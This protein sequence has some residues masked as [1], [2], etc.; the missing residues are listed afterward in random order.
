VPNQSAQGARR[1]QGGERGPLQGALRPQLGQGASDAGGEHR[2]AEAVGHPSQQED[3]EVRLQ[4]Q[5]R[6][7]QALAQVDLNKKANVAQSVTPGVCMHTGSRLAP[8]RPSCPFS[9]GLPHCRQMRRPI[10]A[11]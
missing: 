1:P 2:R 8:T 9:S 10:S 4:A 7:G 6:L 5:C 3:P 11:E